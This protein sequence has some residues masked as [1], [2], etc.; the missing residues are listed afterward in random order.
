MTMTMHNLQHRY[1]WGRVSEA[2]R[3][4]DTASLEV[5]EYVVTMCKVKIAGY[6]LECAADA[7]RADREIVLAAVTQSG[8]AL[9]YAAPAI[10]AD[11]EIV[12]AQ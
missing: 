11:R 8:W 5:N 1:L 2:E 4:L 6:A 3:T 12:L 10:Q 9:E 7:L